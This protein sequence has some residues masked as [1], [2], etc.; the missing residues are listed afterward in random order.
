M[1]GYIARENFVVNHLSES[2][3][4]FTWNEQFRLF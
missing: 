4:L 3:F 2:I 1:G